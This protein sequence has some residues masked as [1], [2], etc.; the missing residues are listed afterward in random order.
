MINQAVP[1]FGERVAV[2]QYD[3][4]HAPVGGCTTAY[5]DVPEVKSTEELG[6]CHVA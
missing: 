5:L 6:N 1:L 2:A 4:S 3:G